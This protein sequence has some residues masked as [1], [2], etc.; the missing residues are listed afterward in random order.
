MKG[1]TVILP[2]RDE[3]D[4]PSFITLSPQ[5]SELS[6]EVLIDKIKGVIYGQAIG[7]AVGLGI[8]YLLLH[9]LFYSLLLSLL[10][11]LNAATEFLNKQECIAYYGKYKH[12]T[13]KAFHKDFHRSRWT[14]GDWTDDTGI[15]IIIILIIIVYKDEK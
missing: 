11:F 9:S 10:M 12:I 2:P 15:V 3:Y 14:P 8:T 4:G 13:F 7:D 1:R 6:K 5:A